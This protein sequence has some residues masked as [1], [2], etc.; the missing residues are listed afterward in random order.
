MKRRAPWPLHAL[1]AV[2]YGV[3]GPEIPVAAIE[4][5]EATT[6]DWKKFGGRGIRRGGAREWLYMC[7]KRCR[8][9]R[10]RG[11][12]GGGTRRAGD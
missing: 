5:C 8:R 9:A 1:L 11:A 6:Y 12:R 3:F 7:M 10:I 4:L 2:P